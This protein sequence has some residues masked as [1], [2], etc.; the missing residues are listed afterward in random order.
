[1]RAA[2][3]ARSN[4][5]PCSRSASRPTATAAEKPAQI[6]DRFGDL[7][8]A[9]AEHLIVRVHEVHE[10][11]RIERLARDVIPVLRTIG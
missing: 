5:R 7:S 3:L 9:G 6:I 2:T 1:M 10:P 4:D 11:A 8:D